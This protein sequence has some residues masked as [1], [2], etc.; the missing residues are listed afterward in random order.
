M[1]KYVNEEIE[2]DEDTI[3]KLKAIAVEHNATL[4]EVVNEAL[5]AAISETITVGDFEKILQDVDEN[6]NQ[7]RLEHY[8]IIVDDF[9]KPI[10]RVI[11]LK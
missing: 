9:K 3:E 6:N 5:V 7:E 8:Y 4:D 1:T 10:A 11:P 2:L